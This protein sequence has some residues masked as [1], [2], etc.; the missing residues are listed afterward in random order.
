MTGAPI[1]ILLVRALSS[2]LFGVSATDAATFLT[3][4]LLLAVVSALA[5]YIP[6]RRAT[7]VDPLSAISSRG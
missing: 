2:M 5:T 7:R 6:T 3:M 4:P 1:A